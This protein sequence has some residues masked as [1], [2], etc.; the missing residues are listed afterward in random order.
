MTE[1]TIPQSIHELSLSRWHKAIERLTVEM[2]T[3][4]KS[5]HQD[6]AETEVRDYLGDAQVEN[7][8]QQALRG[9]ASLE[10]AQTIQECL[11]VLRT[12]VGDA[13]KTHGVDALLSQHDAMSRRLKVLRDI[14][15]KQ[16]VGNRVSLDELPKLRQPAEKSTFYGHTTKGIPVKVMDE[17]Q[18]NTLSAQSVRLTI[19]VYKLADQLADRNRATL[20]LSL[21]AEMA[22]LAAL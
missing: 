21:P 22:A 19:L 6:L 7:L 20:K 2:N 16:D 13:N 11:V 4:H 3:L 5:A 1:P 15:A 12:A 8:R 17:A 14:L 9:L 18:R 10:R